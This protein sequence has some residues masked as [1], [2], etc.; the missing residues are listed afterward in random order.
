MI[1]YS[2]LFDDCHNKPICHE[3]YHL[4]HKLTCKIR[5]NNWNCCNIVVYYWLQWFPKHSNNGRV[6]LFLLFKFLHFLDW[7]VFVFKSENLY[8]FFFFFQQSFIHFL[9][10]VFPS[11]NIIKTKIAR[12]LVI[13]LKNKTKAAENRKFATIFLF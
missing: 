5:K 11:F 3:S 9:C 8:I 2:D 7:E 13:F 6:N 12:N 10:K 1:K 4:A